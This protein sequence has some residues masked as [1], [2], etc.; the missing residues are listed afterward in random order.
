MA[1]RIYC[2]HPLL[3]DEVRGQTHRDL[4]NNSADRVHDGLD[5]H[6]RLVEGTVLDGFNVVRGNPGNQTVV[7]YCAFM[8]VDITR[9]TGHDVHGVFWR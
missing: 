1:T 4:G 2:L 6:L 8:V 7:E 3:V 9:G 5:Q